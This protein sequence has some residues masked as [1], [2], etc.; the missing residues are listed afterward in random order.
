MTLSSALPSMTL[1]S[2]SSDP[3]PSEALVI[4]C[5]AAAALSNEVHSSSARSSSPSK[6]PQR[7]RLLFE[8]FVAV[9]CS[10]SRI[11]VLK[12]RRWSKLDRRILT[13]RPEHRMRSAICSVHAYLSINSPVVLKA[14]AVDCLAPMTASWRARLHSPVSLPPPEVASHRRSRSNA[15]QDSTS[16]IWTHAIKSCCLRSH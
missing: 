6:C 7:Q 5:T 11:R 12:H 15:S 3:S 4:D 14:A 16:A 1:R 8:S 13:A 10:T 9:E 2:D